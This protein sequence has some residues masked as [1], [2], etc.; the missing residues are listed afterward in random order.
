MSARSVWAPPWPHTDASQ[1]LLSHV[2]DSAVPPRR[3]CATCGT[4]C[5]KPTLGLAA[6]AAANAA[7]GCGGPYAQSACTAC[8]TCSATRATHRPSSRRPSRWRPRSTRRCWRAWRARSRTRR[9]PRPTSTWRGRT[10]SGGRRLPRGLADGAR[11]QAAERPASKY[12][13]VAIAARGRST[14]SLR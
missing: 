7:R 6:C 11:V 8:G 5:P 10:R 9:A 2:T 13:S 14:P 12:V 1:R 3:A 4:P